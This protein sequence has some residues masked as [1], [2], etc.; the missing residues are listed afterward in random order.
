MIHDSLPGAKEAA[1][2]LSTTCLRDLSAPNP[3]QDGVTTKFIVSRDDWP[4]PYLVRY[5]LLL[6]GLEDMGLWDKTAFRVP[7]SY[8][9][10]AA[11]V[12]S[13]PVEN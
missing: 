6:I 10:R 1:A 8:R 13:T 7:F 2:K 3:T 4:V 9:G 5:A 11:A 12:M